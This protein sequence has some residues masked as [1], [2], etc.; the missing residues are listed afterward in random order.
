MHISKDLKLMN[1]GRMPM[2]MTSPPSWCGI[3]GSTFRRTSFNATSRLPLKMAQE[4]AR[5][6][7]VA[8]HLLCALPSELR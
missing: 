2:K 3:L 6:D 1:Q 4:S 8:I 7:L 5:G